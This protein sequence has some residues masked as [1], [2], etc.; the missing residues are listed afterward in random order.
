MAESGEPLSEREIEVLRLVATG[1]T[2]RQVAQELTISLNTVKTHLR[3]I[4]AKLEVTSRT[5]ASLHA[6]REG[7]VILKEPSTDSV[8]EAGPTGEASAAVEE[9]GPAG[10]ASPA[11]EEAGAVPSRWRLAP[12]WLRWLG[13]SSV[14]VLAIALVLVILGLPDRWIWPGP[15]SPSATASPPT[16]PD[17]W[18]VRSD[19]PTPRSSPVLVPF[20]GQ[21]YAIGGEG[22]EG[23]SGAVERYDPAQDTWIRLASKPTAVTEAQGAVLSGRI[24]VPGG[25]DAQGRPADVLEAYEM[26]S[27]RWITVAS[28]PRPLSAYALAAFEGDIY[29]FG[30]WDG[31]TYRDEILRYDAGTDRWEEIGQLPFP[32]AYVGAVVARDRILLLGGVNEGGPIKVTLEYSPAFLTW[33]TK[34]VPNITLGQ[35][36]ATALTS[37]FL[38]IV[39]DSGPPASPQLWQYVVRTDRWHPIEPEPTDLHRGTTIAG[40]GTQIFLMG[41]RDGKAPLSQVRSYIALFTTSPGLPGSAP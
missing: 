41:G 23:V 12:G 15:N 9:A 36:Q 26:E 5:E 20:E 21:L 7:W 33:E 29:L 3:N 11:V 2:N 32:W 35:T 14:A 28:L 24:Y 17:R 34:A 10:E 4:F 30:G 31:S 18:Q 8:E 6:V 16:V 27:N 39:A 19:M 25:R 1:A 40:L 22:L 38:Y 37:D 13:L